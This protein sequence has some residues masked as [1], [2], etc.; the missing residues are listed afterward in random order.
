MLVMRALDREA[1]EERSECQQA[2][3]QLQ[4]GHTKKTTP[5]CTGFT[6]YSELASRTAVLV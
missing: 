4:P 6:D 1:G 2:S 3:V 5:V